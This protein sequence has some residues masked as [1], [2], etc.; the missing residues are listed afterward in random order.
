MNNKSMTDNTLSR[1]EKRACP[2]CMSMRQDTLVMLTMSQLFPVNPTLDQS[3]FNEKTI[4]PGFELPIVR[5]SECSFV[6]SLYKMKDHVALS[7]YNEAILAEKSKEKIYKKAKRRSLISLWQQL[8]LLSEDK[9]TLKVLDFGAGWGDFLA[10]AK[11]PGV[12]VHGLEFDERKIHFSKAQGVRSGGIDFIKDNAPYDIFMCNQVLEHLDRPGDALKQIRS[13]LAKNAVGFV[14]VPN[15]SDDVLEKHIG[16]LYKGK[17]EKN[18]HPLEH[19]NYFTPFSFRQMIFKAGFKEVAG[20]G[21][22]AAS[23]KSSKNSRFPGFFNMFKAKKQPTGE[24][25]N[26]FVTISAAHKLKRNN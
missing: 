1:L 13:F 11:S 25:T 7:Y 22:K 5:C 20:D 17:V 26:I 2:F 10:I 8:H 19:L 23:K 6:Y 15:F 24:S 14:A 4:P 18:L 16:A 21:F 3:W 9:D 12:E